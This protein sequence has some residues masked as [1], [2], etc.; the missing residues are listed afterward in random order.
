MM[1]RRLSLAIISLLLTL[2]PGAAAS[3]DERDADVVTVGPSNAPGV[4]VEAQSYARGSSQ[5]GVGSTTSS[6]A[7]VAVPLAETSTST[8][9]P[10]TSTEHI[11]VGPT[12]GSPAPSYVPLAVAR[13]LPAGQ[14]APCLINLGPNAAAPG[15]S[16]GV[17]CSVPQAP[18]GPG[19]APRA[20]AAPGRGNNTT[21]TVALP[22]P[23]ELAAIA[24]DKAMSLAPTPVIE[25]APSKVGLTGL[26]SFVW[27]RDK[28]GTISATAGVPGLTVTA[29]ASPV[30]YVWD[31]GDGTD[32][33][34]ATSGR[35]WSE[36]LPGDISHL[37]ETKG[38]YEL[39]VEVIWEARWRVA[40]GRWQ[41]LGFFANS[42][43]QPYAV[44]EVVSALVPS[45]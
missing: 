3:S 40:G 39:G 4:G 41:P 15:N 11:S 17:S 26:D 22:S 21:T 10:M 44:K 13:S 43:S 20:P 36:S 29:E 35:P 24:A 18:A 1:S 6:T 42:G 25:V 28:P 16:A 2:F 37:Y 14:A 38:S 5:A 7:S 31:F 27:L 45:R 23:E 34:S 30:E 32:V 19:P 9:S 12:G 33:V 8:T